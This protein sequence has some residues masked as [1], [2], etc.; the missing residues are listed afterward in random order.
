M[1]WTIQN[2]T[3]KIWIMNILVAM[4]DPHLASFIWL[5]SW[6][7]NNHL[8]INDDHFSVH[9]RFK[10]ISWCFSFYGIG[11]FTMKMISLWH[12]LFKSFILTPSL[13][14]FDWILTRSIPRSSEYL[15][16]LEDIFVHLRLMQV[17]WS[18]K[19]VQVQNSFILIFHILMQ[20]YHFRFQSH[21]IRSK[22]GGPRVWWA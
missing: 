8:M 19:I 12:G 15:F 1:K 13:V 3:I 22:S 2:Q 10:K 4:L 7:R 20:F 16:T 11:K 9:L 21:H 14:L 17:L 6:I 18:L 5:A